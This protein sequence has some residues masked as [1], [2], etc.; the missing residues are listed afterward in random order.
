MSIPVFRPF[1]V[2]VTFLDQHPTEA[3]HVLAAD[4]AHAVVRAIARMTPELHA[5]ILRINVDEVV[6]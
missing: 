6:K 4:P 3:D 1:V 2:A 5:R